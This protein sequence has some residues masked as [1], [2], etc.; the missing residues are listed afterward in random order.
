LRIRGCLPGHK[1]ASRQ[2]APIARGGGK[3]KKENKE[4]KKERK[5]KKKEKGKRKGKKERKKDNHKLK[6]LNVVL[7]RLTYILHG[8][9]SFLRS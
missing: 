2:V 6:F 7:P 4:T 9:E 8:A 1:H 3:R 5:G